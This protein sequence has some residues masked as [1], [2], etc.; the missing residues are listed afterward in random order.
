MSKELLQFFGLDNPEG[1]A[2]IAREAAKLEA[3]IVR[4][5]AELM[6]QLFDQA[7]ALQQIFGPPD[8]REGN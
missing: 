5:S 7:R 3:E 1:R 4:E 6:N 8:T 2:L